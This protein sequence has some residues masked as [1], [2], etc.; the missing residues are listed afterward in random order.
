MIVYLDP[1]SYGTSETDN[2]ESSSPDK[3]LKS[4]DNGRDKPGTVL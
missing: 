2:G 1:D 4:D 3:L